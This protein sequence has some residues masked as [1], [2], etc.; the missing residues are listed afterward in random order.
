MGLIPGSGRSFGEENGNPIQSSSL[1]NIMDKGA[2][3]ATI[4]WVAKV[5]D[6]IQQLKHSNMYMNKHKIGK[7]N[8]NQ[9][10]EKY[11]NL[12]SVVI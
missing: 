8:K 2:W 7:Q 1:G 12:L 9:E 11:K 4:H 6:T 3:Q 10:K 5:L